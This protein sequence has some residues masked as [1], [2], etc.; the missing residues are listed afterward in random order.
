MVGGEVACPAEDKQSARGSLRELGDGSVL[1][2]ASGA[3]QGSRLGVEVVT[4]GLHAL[5][6]AE[7]LHNPNTT[8]FMY[9]ASEMRSIILP[10]CTPSY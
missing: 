5:V 9:P 10:T 3:Q 1:I 7:G 6:R 4:Q 8:V 2:A